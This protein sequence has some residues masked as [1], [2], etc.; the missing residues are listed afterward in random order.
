MSHKILMDVEDLTRADLSILTSMSL[1]GDQSA[2]SM[3]NAWMNCLTYE[4]ARL[5]GLEG[6][7]LAHT[8]SSSVLA[9]WDGKD[10]INEA[11]S[12]V[13]G[14]THFSEL[15]EKFFSSEDH[16]LMPEAEEE[17]TFSLVGGLRKIR[18]FIQ[19]KW[20]EFRTG[21]KVIEI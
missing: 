18:N 19:D 3:L 16:I 7:Q 13:E 20:Y 8:S 12:V 5:G 6:W 17:S 11:G 9:T 4:D 10:F 1:G 21:D 2:I 14:V 15:P